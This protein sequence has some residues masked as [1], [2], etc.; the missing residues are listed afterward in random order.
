MYE[1]DSSVGLTQSRMGGNQYDRKIIHQAYL[2]VMD[3]WTK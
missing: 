3:E 1:N 2:E